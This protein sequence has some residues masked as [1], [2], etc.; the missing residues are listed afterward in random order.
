MLFINSIFSS[1]NQPLHTKYESTEGQSTI[2][3]L[4]FKKNGDLAWNTYFQLWPINICFCCTTLLNTLLLKTLKKRTGIKTLIQTLMFSFKET[5]HIEQQRQKSLPICQNISRYTI[6]NECTKTAP[7]HIAIRRWRRNV[8]LDLGGKPCHS[9]PKCMILLR[10]PIM[11][12]SYF[13][14]KMVT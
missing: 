8:N 12:Y 4:L 7:W 13:L 6:L 10:F 11:G 14:R 2:Y 5:H 1:R 3:S 9:K